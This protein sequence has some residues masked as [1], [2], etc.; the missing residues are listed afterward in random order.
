M[1]NY[2]KFVPQQSIDYSKF[3]PRGPMSIAPP[4]A[5]KQPGFLDTIKQAGSNFKQVLVD[6]IASAQQKLAP[7]KMSIEAKPGSLNALTQKLGLGVLNKSN[8]ENLTLGM[9]SPLNVAGKVATEVVPIIKTPVQKLTELLDKFKPLRTKTEGL[10]TAER[11]TRISKAGTIFEGAGGQSG[12]Y[13][14]LGQ[15]KGKLPQANVPEGLQKEILQSLNTS[16]IDELFNKVQTSPILNNFEKVSTGSGLAKVLQGEIPTEGELNSLEVV[17]GADFANALKIA[18]PWEFNFMNVANEVG[19]TMKIILSSFLD[20]SFYARQGV[21]YATRHPAKGVSLIK[22]GAKAMVSEGY[23][24]A[25][26]QTIVRD[27]YYPLAKKFGLALTDTSDRAVKLSNQDE[28][29]LIKWITKVPVIGPIVKAT[30]RAFVGMSNKVRM[31][32]FHSVADDLVKAGFDPIKNPK[33]FTT[34]TKFVNS[35]SGRGNLGK[36]LNNMTELTNLAAWSPR[37]MA[38]RFQILFSPITYGNAPAPVRKEVVK[39]LLSYTGTVLTVLGIAKANGAEVEVDPYSSN[40]GKIKYGNSYWDVTGGLGA[41][42]R[43]LVQ[44]GYG[45]KKDIS[46]GKHIQYNR[47]DTIKNF[48]RSKASPIVSSV[49]DIVKGQN[50]NYQPV[51]PI[52]FLRD[53]FVPLTPSDIISAS[54][55]MPWYKALFTAGIPTFFG[56]G[57][58]RQAPKESNSRGRSNKRNTTR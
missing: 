6:P 38:S 12:F 14:G 21:M 34:A 9:T 43:Y 37:L 42:V 55:D 56:V 54:Q 26:N 20:M 41:Y 16:G 44:F 51:T 39:T 24:N 48:A 58:Q 25:L 7:K 5:P 1:I 33:A 3:V 2:S 35:F 10:Y 46:T 32:W 15:L 50:F 11:A 31:D 18:K 17:F 45:K 13:R 30:E 27:S 49:V 28:Q 23:Y 8:I 19:G 52:Q 4:V 36:S 29:F 40:F 22:T 57:Y 53:H 47:L